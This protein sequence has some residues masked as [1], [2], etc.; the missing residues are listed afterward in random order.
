MSVLVAKEL[1]SVLGSK[2]SIGRINIG[3]LN[4][5]IIDDLLLDDQ[6]GKE[7]LKVSRLSA[8]FDIIPLF[9]GKISISNVQLFSFNANL[10]KQTPDAKSNFQFV[11]DAFASKDSVKKKSNLDLRIN[12]LLIR[13]GRVSYDIRSEQETPGKFNPKHIRL[14]NILA[15][16]SLKALQSDSINAAIKRMS[17]EE[18]HSGFEL[19]KLSLKVVANDRKMRI[20][21]FAIDLPNTS[22]E[23]DTIR[24]EYDSLGAFGNFA[25]DVRFS[26]HILPSEVVLQDLSAFV[27]AFKPFKEKIKLEVETDGTIN[28]LNCPQLLI[29]AG[30]HFLL[31]G[32]VS[33]QDLS[34]PQD[35]FIYGNLSN[36]YADQEGIAFFVRN[37]SNDYKGVPP[38]LQHL[39]TVAFRGEISGY[40][41]D[42]VTYGEVRTDIGSLK[43]DIKLSSDKEK[44]YFSYSGAIKTTEFELGKLLGNDKFG[45]VTFNMDV[46]GNHYEKRYPTILMKGLLESIDYSDYTYEN[47]TLDGEYKQGGFNGKIALDDENVSLEMNGAINIAT[48]IPTF[49]FRASLEHFRPHNLHLSPKYEDTEISV[50]VTADFTGGSIDDMNGEIN[51]DSLQFTAPDKNYF[52]DNL[53]IAAIQK[54]KQHKLLTI[55]SGFLKGSIEGDYSYQTLPGS[56]LNIMRRYIPALIL[57]DKKPQ[58]TENNFHFDLHIFD[59]E[60][61]S[62]VFQIPVKVYTHSTLKGYFNDKAQR[63][64]VEGYFPRL[65]YGEKFIESGMLL[66]E[67]PGEQFQARVR[68]TNR[69]VNGAVNVALEAQAKDDHIQTV[70]N[71][72]NSSSVT[73]SGKLAAV[74]QFIRAREDNTDINKRSSRKNQK[75][76][77]ALKTVVD[78]QPTHVI[79]NDTLWQIHPSQ[80]VVDSG[81]VH[82]NNFYFSH[83]ERHLRINGIVSDQPQDTVRLNLQDINIGYVFDI[84]NLG[85]NF[86]GEATGPAYASGVL[87]KPVMS[88]DLFIRN[89]GLNDGLLGDANI[90]GEWHHDVKGIYLDAHIRE[91]DI[92]KSHVYGYVYPIKP[93]SSLDLQIEANNTN[94]KFIHHYMHSITPEFSGRATGHVHFYGKFKA[95]TME[96]RVFGD[97]SLKVDVL[98]TTFSLKDSIII[99]PDGLTFHNNR[100]FDTRGHQGRMNGYLHYQHFKNLEYRFQFDV[101]NMLVMNTKESLDYPFYGTVYGTGNATIAGNAADGVNIDVAMTTNRNTNFV[102]M[103]EGV[104]SAVSNQFIRFVDKTPRRAVQDSILLI[105]DFEQAQK[106]IAEKESDTDIRLNLLIDATPDATMK[107]IMDPIAG[108]YISGK[109]SGNIRT[110]FYNKGDVKMFGNYRI[111]QGIYKFSLQEVIRKDFTIKDGSYINF[112]GPPLDAT[113]DIRAS[114][115]VSSASL[116]DLVPNAGNYVDQTNIKVNCIMDLTGQLTSPSLKLS[117]ELPNERDEVQALI[118]NYI[119]TEEQMN[120]QILYLLG[121]GKFYTPENVDA[122]GNSNMMSS[123]LSSTLSGQLNNALSHIIDSNNWNIGTNFSTG[124]KGWT[125]MEFETMLSGQLLNNRLL[126]NGNFGYRDNPIAN[127]NFVG[128]FQAEWL[129]NRSGDIRLKAYNE[130]ND[131]YYTKTNLTTQ[132]IGIVFKKDFNKWNE[133]LFWNKW[134]LKR[135]KKLQEKKEAAT[136]DS[137]PPKADSLHTNHQ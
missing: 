126:I 37:L 21:N 7:L 120:M 40:F 127:T 29:S 43:T 55:N 24:M 57:P 133:L 50:K 53:Q 3:L 51:I 86:K 34:H 128:D 30:K 44:G 33:L 69:K 104:A 88:T 112:N 118:R 77:S 31:R 63:L 39:G 132:G 115:L 95:L 74:A 66:C 114:Y 102:Y 36:L 130:T 93:T 81:K 73:Y 13:R 125:D 46:K 100:I 4:R 2:L 134:K 131:R 64:R 16:I 54:D 83:E 82:I 61:L 84:A 49:N 108:D 92:A 67:N 22:L 38:A 99:Q 72:G 52:M 28:Q 124:E 111:S 85:V 75:E 15:N 60:L 113:L 12:S 106:E 14:S 48:Q 96:G 119:P 123:V 17:V 25:K 137:I 20:E 47:I 32:D 59:T 62:T 11:L 107:I 80:I 117:I 103:K 76:K 135:L 6:S 45:K 136:T 68:F 78:V 91:K 8:K 109:G 87:K 71:W 41:T 122:T 18:E 116:N 129:V 35:A 97:A 58:E 89:L 1:S 105:S 101:N 56:V 26:F 42:L 90:H 79:L 65:S 121:I 19:K 5:I 10:E 70:L 27:P 110:E 9:N 94:L 23:A 98:N